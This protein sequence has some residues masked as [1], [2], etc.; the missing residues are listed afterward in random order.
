MKLKLRRVFAAALAL[1]LALSLYIH[2]CALDADV[3]PEPKLALELSEEPSQTRVPVETVEPEDEGKPQSIS[4]ETVIDVSVPTSG[5]FVINPYRM[6]V[7]SMEDTSQI[8]HSPQVIYNNTDSMVTVDVSIMGTVP[9]ES[10]AVF[11]SEPPVEERKEVFLY[12]EFQNSPD[13]WSD[14]YSGSSNQLVV[15]EDLTY[16]EDVLTLD[17]HGEGYFRFFGSMSEGVFWEKTD[18][19]NA[20]LVFTFFAAPMEEEEAEPEEVWEAPELTDDETL[21]PE[22]AWEP[23]EPEE[24]EGLAP[25][26]EKPAGPEEDERLTSEKP[27][28]PDENETETPGEAEGSAEPAGEETEAPER[29]EEPAGSVHAETEEPSPALD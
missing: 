29:A 9:P 15:S 20:V 28:G 14:A 3:E 27:A 16:G 18:A 7:G 19:F 11:V 23:A 25:E 13:F 17:A 10:E 22:E 6:P 4:A 5:Q 8:V 1:C 24:D 2:V 12:T 26:E 21:A